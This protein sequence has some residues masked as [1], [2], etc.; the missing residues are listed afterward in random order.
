M[1]MGPRDT[2]DL[3]SPIILD[4]VKLEHKVEPL[5]DLITNNFDPIE[6][7]VDEMELQVEKVDEADGASVRSVPSPPPTPSSTMSYYESH[8]RVASQVI[9]P[10]FIAGIGSVG[11]GLYLA[12]M[13][14]W[15]AFVHMPETL[16]LVPALLGLKGN[17]E[18]TLASRLSTECNIGNMN[19]HRQ[20]LQHIIGNIALNQCR[21]TV[22]GMLASLFASL[23]VLIVQ[24]VFDLQHTLILCAI[25][26]KHCKINPDNVATPVSASFGDIFALVFLGLSASVLYAHQE[27]ANWLCPIIIVLFLC[28]LPFWIWVVKKNCCRDALLNGWSP[29]LMA[30][31]ISTFAGYIFNIVVARSSS[32][33]V[34]QPVVNGVAGNLVAVQASKMATELHREAELGILPPHLRVCIIQTAVTARVLLMLVIP[35]HLVF[36]Y[37]ISYIQTHKASLSPIFLAVYL[38]TVLFQVAFV[39]YI[40]A[41]ITSFFWKRKKNP[42]N[43]TIPYL[44]ALADLMGICLMGAAF[45]L[46]RLFGEEDV[47]Q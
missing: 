9:A 19:T 30:M 47:L 6:L 34:F 35:G 11:A 46:L 26:S 25:T 13:Q 38:P 31:L 23:M 43:M 1:K 37:S 27:I 7:S 33:A 15:D 42:D 2:M 14:D 3:S 8:R 41:V 17:L 5:P 40:A 32:V 28:L 22:V 44:T 39:L 24:Q 36:I 4:V 16:I 29:V 12:M 10:F 20:K 18:M 21:A 45:E